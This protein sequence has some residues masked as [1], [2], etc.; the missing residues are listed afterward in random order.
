MMSLVPVCFIHYWILAGIFFI[1]DFRRWPKFIQ[2]YKIR[3]EKNIDTDKLFEAIR[4]VVFNQLIINSSVTY[5]G[6][7]LFENFS[8]FK[9][10][11]V[12]AVAPFP[13]LMID[14]IGCAIIYELV[15]FYSHCLLHHKLLYKHIHKVHHEWKAPVAAISQY[16]HPIEH[17]LCNLLPP[18]AGFII[19]QTNLST[20]FLFNLYI[21]TMTTLEHSGYNLPFFA[22]PEY[23]DYHH[24][25][26][27]ECF[28]HRIL[29]TF[30]GTNKT[31]REKE[32]RTKLV[33]KAS[34]SFPQMIPS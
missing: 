18:F 23:H 33:L 27:V 2:K 16:C 5:I 3:R 8:F 17:V 11:D 1:S 32:E 10:I 24:E 4:V 14:L 30:H 12:A 15:F 20:A 29:D 6:V 19:L 21:V 31:Y 34:E 26:F 9:K 28:G 13:K 7:Y 25:K 22:Q